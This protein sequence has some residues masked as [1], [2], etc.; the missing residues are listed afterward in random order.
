MDIYAN[1]R[2]P[3][4]M[5][6]KTEKHTQATAVKKPKSLIEITAL[7]PTSA[8]ESARESALKHL[9][10]EV[11]IKG[12]RKGHAPEEMVIAHV[13]EGAVDAHAFEDALHAALPDLLAS[14]APRAIAHPRLLK[15]A[16]KEGGIEIVL[17]VSVLPEITL[18][19]YKKI[20]AK[21]RT[22]ADDPETASITEE[23]YR[24]ELKEHLRAY[25]RFVRAKL[26]PESDPNTI[27]IKDEDIPALTDDVAKEMGPFAN[28]LDLE[29]RL[30]DSLLLRKKQT[31]AEKRRLA[32]LDAVLSETK[33]ELPDVMVEEELAQILNE[34]EMNLTRAGLTL[35][36][37]LAHIKKTKEDIE[38]EWRPNAEKRALLELV[39]SE[40]ARAEKIEPDQ[41]KVDRDVAHT[42]E[43]L[44][45][46]DPARVR[47]FIAH[48]LV[49]EA[50]MEL[51]EKAA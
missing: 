35:E 17:E 12:F 39:L 48:K 2:Y 31:L 20:A 7:I 34:F 4:C 40:I 26:S 14:H 8:L 11:E 16:K 50:V 36:Q 22:G 47:A 38:A 33:A 15:S 49:N 21:E 3:P 28:A 44:K 6:S 10:A 37:Y 46:A 41:E 9:G 19:D 18:P 23:E 51:L 5:S 32:I 24:A 1:L 43:H 13:G 27:E 30:R 45:D 29:T 25:A 42:L